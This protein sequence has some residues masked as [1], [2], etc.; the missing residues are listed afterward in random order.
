MT[1]IRDE[2]SKMA[3]A[4]FPLT[5]ERAYLD[6]ACIGVA[7]QRTV[8]AVTHFTE[9]TQWIPADSGTAHHGELNTAR[10]AAR[11]RVARLIGAQ[12]Q[13]I[14]LVESATHGLSIAAQALPLKPGDAVALADLEYIQMGVTWS[15][16]AR[17]GIGIRRV[18]H[19]AGEVSVD[20]LRACLDEDVAVLALSSVQWTNGFRADLAAVS[21]MCRSRGIWLVV[22]AAQHVGA[23]PFDV[24]TAPVDILVCSGHKWLNSPF[25]TGF[26][27]LAPGIRERLHRPMAGF[28][29][30]EPPADTWGKAFLRPDI[31]P[32][33]DFT[34]TGDARAW[35]IGGTANYPG[36]IALASALD[37]VI[38]VGPPAMADHIIALT[39]QLLA[40]L[41]RLGLLVVTP[42]RRRFRSG[43]VTFTLGT[44]K[45]DTAL[46]DCLGGAGVA[47]SVRYTAGV[48]GVRVSCHWFNSPADVGLLLDVVGYFTR[49]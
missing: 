1:A 40:G 48:G 39:D 34:Y 45:A 22:D 28:F 13:D 9:R 19:T 17:S 12:P 27:Y 29:A 30:A 3:S 6:A 41:D 16:L 18:P 7:A 26:L 46:M 15:Q 11:P 32:F 44:S 37:L 36:G 33:Q 2:L 10:D 25:G 4:E 8:D 31:S 38:E 20:V 21:E 47:V 43:I 14:A 49:C 23:L 42:R 5:R 35:E 24:S